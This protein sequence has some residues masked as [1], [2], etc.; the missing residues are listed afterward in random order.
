VE[1]TFGIRWLGGSAPAVNLAPAIT[2]DTSIESEF[3]LG[4]GTVTD[5]QQQFG[6]DKDNL[7]AILI[8]VS[9]NPAT[10]VVLE[11]NAVDA[12]GGQ[13]LTFPAGGGELLWTNRSPLAN[14]ITA[15][16]TTT[17]WTKSGVDTPR[18]KVRIL[19]NA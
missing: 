3:T 5:Q 4:A 18:V 14:P 10:T 17:Y 19:F 8:T 1:Q 15:D 9:D 7:K 12:T 13:T 16:V 2:G 11:T 6:F